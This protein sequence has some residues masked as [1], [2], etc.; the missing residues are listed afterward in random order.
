M[1]VLK[2]FFNKLV[3]RLLRSLTTNTKQYEQIQQITIVIFNK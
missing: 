3:V 1:Q 2:M